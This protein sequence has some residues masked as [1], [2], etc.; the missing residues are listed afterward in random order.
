MTDDALMFQ[1]E[2]THELSRKELLEASY[3][4]ELSLQLVF[5]TWAHRRA[6]EQGLL[7][8]AFGLLEG[9]IEQ[10]HDMVRI[11]GNLLLLKT[12][13]API[14]DGEFTEVAEAVPLPAP[15][16]RLPAPE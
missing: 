9:S 2:W 7:V 5:Q 15:S 11:K 4:F 6:A 14:I 1:E 8:L 3:N 12:G 13:E 10:Y 16:R